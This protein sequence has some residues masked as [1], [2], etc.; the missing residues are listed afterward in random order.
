MASSTKVISKWYEENYYKYRVDVEELEV[1]SNNESIQGYVLSNISNKK[2]NYHNLDERKIIIH[3]L[4]QIPISLV[5]Y[6]TFKD[7]KDVI[8][9]KS[10]KT[11]RISKH[12]NNQDLLGTLEP[13]LPYYSHGHYNLIYNFDTKKYSFNILY[14]EGA[15]IK[16]DAY[17]NIHAIGFDTEKEIFNF[18][19]KARSFGIQNFLKE[20]EKI[21]KQ[22]AIQKEKNEKLKQ[23]IFISM[24]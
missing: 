14:S 17:C 9:R 24:P 13:I 23:S 5:E 22:Q 8:L 12:F 16:E 19:K 2:F 20:K 10:N 3:A 15:G 7:F 6:S 11:L 18:I 4:S 21:E 1:L